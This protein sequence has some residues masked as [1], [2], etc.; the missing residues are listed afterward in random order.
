M[1]MKVNLVHHG[2]YT[3]MFRADRGFPP[4]LLG[5]LRASVG[6][7]GESTGIFRQC[8]TTTP[9]SEL[10]LEVVSEQEA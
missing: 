10:C 7:Y 9:M 8:Q 3:N 4:R 5:Q 1:N 2:G 6:P